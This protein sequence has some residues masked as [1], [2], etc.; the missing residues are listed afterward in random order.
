MPLDS[1]LFQLNNT[2]LRNGVTFNCSCLCVG[3]SAVG[4]GQQRDGKLSEFFALHIP[5]DGSLLYLVLT[6]GTEFDRMSVEG[7]V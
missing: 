6:K 4:Y 5:F 2:T 7:R 3:R 1:P